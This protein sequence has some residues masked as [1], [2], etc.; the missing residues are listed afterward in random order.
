MANIMTF[1]VCSNTS[2]SLLKPTIYSWATT[3]IDGIV[4]TLFFNCAIGFYEEH[5]TNN[6]AKAPKDLLSPNGLSAAMQVV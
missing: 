1:Y 3:W 4:L 5:N 2:D 6:A